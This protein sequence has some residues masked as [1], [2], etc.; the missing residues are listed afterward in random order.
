MPNKPQSQQPEPQPSSSRGAKCP[1]PVSSTLVLLTSGG[2]KFSAAVHAVHCMMLNS[3]FS[4]YP[5]DTSGAHWW[6]LTGPN[7]N[8][9]KQG[10]A[11]PGWGSKLMQL[12]NFR[13]NQSL[14]WGQS[15]NIYILQSTGWRISQELQ[16]TLEIILCFEKIVLWFYRN[17]SHGVHFIHF[18]ELQWLNF[19]KNNYLN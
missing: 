4:F 16:E 7:R 8:V 19:L 6:S 9:S 17:L 1:N 11:C 2:G 12:I 15:W 14:S 18:S 3:I 10:Q 13:L 5:T